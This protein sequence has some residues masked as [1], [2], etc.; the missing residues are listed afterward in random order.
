MSR[1]FRSVSVFE[2]NADIRFQDPETGE[3]LGYL[4]DASLGNPARPERIDVKELGWMVEGGAAF[5]FDLRVFEERLH[6]VVVDQFVPKAGGA[7]NGDPKVF[8][9]VNGEDFDVRGAEAQLRWA[10]WPGARWHYAWTQFESG[11][12]MSMSQS[13]QGRPVPTH[14]SQ[15]LLYIQRLPWGL[16]ASAF[17]YDMGDR[18]YPNSVA[19]APP[20][21]RVDLRLAKTL[22]LDERW[23]AGRQA[24]LS[25][26]WQNIDGD[27][28]D[29]SKDY[30]QYFQRRVFLMLQLGH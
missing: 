29:H 30:P 8:T 23:W 17:A 18:I 16:S 22:R 28:A 3:D 26:T 12:R 21:S 4:Y 7:V 10:P 14:R 19:Y 24:E 5:S 9:F 13:S 2:R 27:D 6:G 11:Q 15:S 25:M 20:Y 1:A